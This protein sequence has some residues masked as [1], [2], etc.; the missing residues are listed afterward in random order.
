MYP[1]GEELVTKTTTMIVRVWR[2]NGALST[3]QNVVVVPHA[4]ESA[5]EGSAQIVHEETRNDRA[6]RQPSSDAVDGF[7]ADSADAG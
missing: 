2:R 1:A 5:R 7:R 4:P 3:T 6:L